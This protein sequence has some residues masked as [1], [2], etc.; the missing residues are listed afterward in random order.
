MQKKTN[1]KLETKAS[2]KLTPT[3][4]KSIIAVLNDESPVLITKHEVFFLPSMG[5]KLTFINSTLA[6]DQWVPS[7][8]HKL[9]SIEIADKRA[10]HTS[11][12][13]CKSSFSIKAGT[14][15]KG[16]PVLVNDNFIATYRF[17]GKTFYDPKLAIVEK[18][19]TAQLRAR[20]AV[21]MKSD[22]VDKVVFKHIRSQMNTV[23]NEG[24]AFKTTHVI[25][26]NKKNGMLCIWRNWKTRKPYDAKPG[27][28]S[29]YKMV[30]TAFK[31]E[32]KGKWIPFTNHTEKDGHKA[33]GRLD[34]NHCTSIQAGSNLGCAMKALDK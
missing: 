6:K 13:P 17:A 34:V 14:K 12:V 18:E 31:Y 10:T 30:M 1:T 19:M 32:E 25:T 33:A 21:Y 15:K 23:L 28:R 27:D 9:I 2:C 22:D 29:E 24:Y 4:R 11:Q 8:G 3:D 20:M 16:D 7:K 5:N 26:Q